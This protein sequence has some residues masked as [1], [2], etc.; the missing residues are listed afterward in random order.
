MPGALYGVGVG[1][2]DPELITL[3]AARLIREADVVAY[4]SGTR[5]AS[6]ARSIAAELIRPDAV[7]ELLA[8]PVTVGQTSH[9]LG[10]Y[11]AIAEFYDASAARLAAH[12]EAGSSVVVLA[13]GDP[14]FYSSYMYLHD[15]L[16]S[17]FPSEIVPGTTS[18]TAPPPPLRAPLARHEAALPGLP[19]TLPV[20]GP[21]RRTPATDAAAIMKL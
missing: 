19:G 2:G 4:H 7:E 14:L 8:Y 6:I 20:P 13:E 18:L 1:P 11:G 15:R 10:Y 9:P 12:L 21:A 17:R 3:R 16:S 5:G